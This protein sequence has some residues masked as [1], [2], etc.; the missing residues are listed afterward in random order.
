MSSLIGKLFHFR[1]RFEDE[2][3]KDKVSKKADK[4]IFVQKKDRFLDSDNA[5]Q[6]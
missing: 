4:I 5:I 6:K 2:L 3:P 1:P